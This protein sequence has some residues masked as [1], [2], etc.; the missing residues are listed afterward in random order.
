MNKDT[1]NS[2]G[3]KS[4]IGEI[5]TLVLAPTLLMSMILAVLAVD[6]INDGIASQTRVSIKS[7]AAT[8]IETMDNMAVGDYVISNGHLCKGT[9]ELDTMAKYYENLSSKTGTKLAIFYGN[10]CIINTI[11]ENAVPKLDDEAVN[12]VMNLGEDYFNNKLSINGTEYF[13]NVEPL[14]N[15]DGTIVGMV[16]A[17]M[18]RAVV[19]DV[20]VDTFKNL[21]ITSIIFLII[22]AAISSI[23][24]YVLVKRLKSVTVTL[25]KI[26]DGNL[27]VNIDEK[28]IARKDEIGDIAKSA[29][30]LKN[31]LGSIVEAL[32]TQADML[33]NSSRKL[34]N[35][36]GVTS[37][38]MEDV[39][40]S[41]N[42]IAIGATEQA[43]DTSKAADSIMNMGNIIEEIA[44]EAEELTD[45]AKLMGN[46]EAQAS[47]M[48]DEFY[49]T[50]DD[51]MKAIDEIYSQVEVTNDSAKKIREAVEI[52]ANIA[53]QTN[54]LSLNATIEAARAGE[55]GRGFAVVAGEIQ[56]LSEQSN[57]SAN[58]IAEI[59]KNLLT[60]SDKTV[61]SMKAVKEAI[62]LQKEKLGKT[63]E[64]FEIVSDG[65]SAS[66]SSIQEIKQK[67]DLLGDEREEIVAKIQ[68]LSGISEENA[69]STEE[70]TAAI[71]ELNATM[72][73]IAIEAANLN[74]SANSV[75]ENIKIFKL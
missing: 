66:L 34:D 65:V 3:K 4:L 27:N 63:K 28:S 17:G 52:I 50:N 31:S 24:A 39:S 16:F 59:V 32:N 30:N 37:S 6:K 10:E 61:E 38:T 67:I 72:S 71:E 54:L 23:I 18:P 35:V 19:T 42:S 12:K 20:V 57:S 44:C 75:R 56:K 64:T 41:V 70:T 15:S 73:E 26:A 22:I 48:M 7:V 14:K 55:S 62:D 21:A 45:S 58:T 53:D 9:K 29:V 2:K 74:E 47:N 40:Q 36:S 33:V 69:A 68:N 43:D 25:E 8:M 1:I 60:E 46:S 11:G 13:C 51:T 5:I 49:K